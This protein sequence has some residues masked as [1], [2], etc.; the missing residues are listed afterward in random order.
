M[1]D[2]SG[3]LPGVALHG[4][5]SDTQQ[6]QRMVCA[7]RG[8]QQPTPWNLPPDVFEPASFLMVVALH[9]QC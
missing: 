3:T 5:Y 8:C 9:Q 7:T 2:V 1:S 6:V 4:R